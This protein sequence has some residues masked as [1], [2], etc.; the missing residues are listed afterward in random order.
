MTRTTGIT[1]AAVPLAA[2]AIAASA[3]AGVHAAAV[4]RTTSA[5]PDGALAFTKKRLTA[6][7]GRITIVMRNP[8]SSGL[9]HAIAIRGKEGRRAAPGETSRVTVRIRK[10]GRYTF[11][12]P[13]DGHRLAGMKGRLRVTS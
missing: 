7:K 9:D 2:L 4:T 3:G 13:I 11:Y 6:P 5:D 12:C 8:M 10:T 1:L